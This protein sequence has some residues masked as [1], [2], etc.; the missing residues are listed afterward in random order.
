VELSAFSQLI[1]KRVEGQDGSSLGRVHEVKARWEG[2]AIVCEELLVGRG[3]VV[4][5]LRGPGPAVRGLPWEAVL[6]IDE[7]RIL[8]GLLDP[9][10]Q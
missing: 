3:G 8:V 6:D 2:R 1:G 9:P 4:T 7:Q 10:Q 5:R